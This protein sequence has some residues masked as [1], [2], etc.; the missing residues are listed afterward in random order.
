MFYCG[1]AIHLAEK[2]I[3]LSYRAPV[4]GRKKILQ[5]NQITFTKVQ[6]IIYFSQ[7]NNK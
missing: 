7:F 2:N 6:N 5:S 4:F 3:Y 1:N